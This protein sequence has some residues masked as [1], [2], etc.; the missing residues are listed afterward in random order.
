MSF[1]WYTMIGSTSLICS[2]A[3]DANCGSNR[4]Q[5]TAIAN[6]AMVAP[7]GKATFH[8][9]R[10]ARRTNAGVKAPD[11]ELASPDLVGDFAARGLS[12]TRAL[13]GRLRL[14]EELCL[15]EV[16]LI[17]LS[18]VLLLLVKTPTTSVSAHR[19]HSSSARSSVTLYFA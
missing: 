8:Q 1:D 15:F 6:A 12:G 2:T 13:M 11:V 10:I 17:V 19:P 14:C 4:C 18:C 9:W 16:S 3:C 7:S 5:T